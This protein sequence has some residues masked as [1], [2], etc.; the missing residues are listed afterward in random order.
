MAKEDILETTGIVIEVLPNANFKVVLENKQVIIA[1]VSG[2]I[3]KNYI[4][5][6]QGDRVTVVISP[7]DTTQ[8]RITYRHK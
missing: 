4:R 7:Y 2:K 8:G 6:L 1:H 5:I 3:R